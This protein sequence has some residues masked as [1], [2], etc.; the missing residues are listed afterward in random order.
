MTH[1]KSYT[2]QEIADFLDVE[3]IGDPQCEILGLGTL[4]GAGTGQ[5]S[6]LSN[7]S[8]ADQLSGC[9]AS[10][11]IIGDQFVDKCPGN[12]LLSASPYVSFA[13]ATSLFATSITDDARGLVHPSASIHD[14]V[15]LGKGVS[16]AA[17]VVIE[18][19]VTIAD[20]S[21]IG[22]A[23]Y[24]GES[25]QLGKNSKLY[26]GVT[27]YNK[28]CIGDNSIIHSGTVIGADGFGFAFDGEASVKIHQLG[29][30]V[31]GDDV[32]IGANTT[33]DRGAIEDTIIGDGVKMDNQVQIAHNVKIGD[34]TMLCGCAGVGGS[35]VI[36]KYCIIGGG[37]GVIGHLN[38][39]DKVHV[40]ALS[41][42]NQSIAEPGIYA[43]GTML[44][45]NALWKRN[46]VRFAQ[47]D[48][49]SKRLKEIEKST[50][51]K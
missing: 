31:I 13:K 8:Y 43:S 23:C 38:I 44:Q 47:L 10:A 51:N 37:V 45:K 9:K 17:N 14:S 15:V 18:A 46:A 25:S 28:V 20:N 33:I 35:T 34:H 41:C 27:I 24:I 36:G 40:G 49:I 22:A 30:V 6:F 16:V 42:V 11:I 26:S 5:L 50:D 48:S 1:N 12:K 39:V 3:L 32:E 19:N 7:P 21:T 29:G 2:L 4:N